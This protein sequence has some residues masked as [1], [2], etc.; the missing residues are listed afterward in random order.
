MSLKGFLNTAHADRLTAGQVRVCVSS[1]RRT[2]RGAHT[3]EDTQRRTHRG[4]HTQRR[5]HRGG[6]TEARTQR[7]IHTEA[8]TQR[9]THTEADT[10][11]GGHAEVLLGCRE[12]KRTNLVT[13][14]VTGR[15]VID[16]AASMTP[17]RACI[18]MPVV[19][20]QSETLY[21]LSR[22]TVHSRNVQNASLL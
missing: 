21:P 22:H 18:M 10:H 5:T 4:G 7:R 14:C 2:H 17:T 19:L 13:C 3:E 20:A 1:L 11:R 9:R 6:H 16:V 15:Q 12:V 8:H